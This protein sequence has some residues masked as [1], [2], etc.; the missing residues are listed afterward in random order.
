M[1]SAHGGT[2]GKGADMEVKDGEKVQRLNTAGT[3]ILVSGINLDL[4]NE[5]EKDP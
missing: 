3:K 5:S 4:L 2:S 1:I